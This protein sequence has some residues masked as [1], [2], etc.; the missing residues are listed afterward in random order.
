[1]SSDQVPIWEEEGV[2][3]LDAV[4]SYSSRVWENLQSE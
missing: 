4:L 3:Y 2:A 1:M